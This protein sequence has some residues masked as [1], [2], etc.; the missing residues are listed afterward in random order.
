MKVMF[1]FAASGVLQKQIE[2]GAPADVFA[3]AGAKQMDGIEAKGLLAEGC[4]YD[5]ARNTLVLIVPA[6][7]ANDIKS[8]ADLAR[9]PAST[10]PYSVAGS[11]T[12]PKITLC[13]RISPPSRIRW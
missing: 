1:N 5:F 4:R 6:D 7:A 8:F 13:F 3:S 10:C 9:P 11:D 12:F 2:A